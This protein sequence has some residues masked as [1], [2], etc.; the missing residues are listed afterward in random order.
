MRTRAS[1]RG[2]RRGD[3]GKRVALTREFDASLAGT[4]V[5]THRRVPRAGRDVLTIADALASRAGQKYLIR[6]AVTSGRLGAA[7]QR[8]VAVPG[9]SNSN[10]GLGIRAGR[11]R[12]I[13]WG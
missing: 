2:A 6:H 8:D 3:S 4:S 9:H 11:V 1:S 12:Y 10:P 13:K 5:L 7:P